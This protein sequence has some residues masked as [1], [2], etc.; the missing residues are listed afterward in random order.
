LIKKIIFIPTIDLVET[1]GFNPIPAKKEIP[2]W[3]KK[4]KSYIIL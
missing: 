4:I 1:L 3:Y 2:K